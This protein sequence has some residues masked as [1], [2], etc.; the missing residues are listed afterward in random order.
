M[1]IDKNYCMSSFL[2]F[3][4]IY[5]KDINFSYNLIHEHFVQIGDDKKLIVKTAD[6][7]DLAIKKQLKQFKNRKVALLLSGGMDSAILS[8]YFKGCDAYTFRFL[9]GEYQTDELRRAEQYAKIYG[10]NLHYVDINWDIVEKNSMLCMKHKAAPIHSIEPQLYEAAIQ[11]KRDG[12]DLIIYGDAADY[13][14]GG[15]DK[16]LSKD[17]LFDDFYK[18]FIYIEPSEVLRNP[19]D[20]KYIFEKYRDG[21]YIKFVE[22]M[23]DV[24]NNES[25]SSYKNAFETAGVDFYDPYERLKM[26]APLDLNRIRSGESKYLIRELF[27]MKFPNLNVPEKVPMPRPVDQYFANWKGPVRKEFLPNLDM[28]YFSGNQKWLLWSLET[29]LNLNNIK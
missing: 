7:I 18:R 23:D 15:M 24:T 4:Y 14:F 25:Y 3:R 5:E 22:M 16:L 9:G 17:W 8:S 13:V 26:G 12:C 19:V 21:I 6:E 11:A 20:V 2:A 28:T 10:L 29:F 27:K 1:K